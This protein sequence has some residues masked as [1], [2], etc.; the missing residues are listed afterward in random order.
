M[1]TPTRW[2]G[3]LLAMV[4]T[5]RAAATESPSGSSLCAPACQPGETCVSGTCM[6]PAAPPPVPAYPPTPGYRAPPTS[7]YYEAP[8]P[9]RPRRFLA[10]PY[11]GTHSYQSGST[12]A[13]F[14]GFRIGGLIGARVTEQVS[15]NWELTFDVSNIE[16]SPPAPPVTTSSSDSSEFAFD[17]AFSPMVHLPAGPAEF[18][19]GPKLGVFWV[20]T[21]VH[22]NS[23]FT[24]V[25]RQGT[26]VLGGLTVGTFMSV[27]GP[28]SLGVLLSGE[29]RKI[30]HACTV[31]AGEIALCDLARDGSAAIV[32]LTAAAIFR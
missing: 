27:S 6:V 19:L 26:G 20:H 11:I 17:F 10:L 1:R 13:Y 18:V 2:F 30:E 4:I 24:G 12:R 32:G 7:S 15:L 25:S 28:V 3:L 21:D 9:A 29:L 16:T 23:S 22:T 5:S 14:P 31:N 8:R